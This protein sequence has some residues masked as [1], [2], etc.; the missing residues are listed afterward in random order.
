MGLPRR[1]PWWLATKDER[2]IFYAGM[3]GLLNLGL[4]LMK[5]LLFILSPSSFLIA[6]VVFSFGV[7][8][9]KLI[10]VRTYRMSRL[11]ANA[12]E[13]PLE[14]QYRATLK[15]G[16][17]LA[18]SAALYM[19]L[20]LPLILG[21]AV[22][23]SFDPLIA[24]ILALVAFTEIGIAIVGVVRTRHATQPLVKAIRVVNLSSS[25]VLLVL[26]QAAILSF[27]STEEWGWGVGLSALI[28]GAIA[29]LS[30]IYLIVR[31]V[32]TRLSRD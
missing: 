6:N 13:P 25:L 15:V 10:A 19:G 2:S 11:S 14:D 17:V 18:I 9:E 8:V 12:V 4:A 16:V 30:G 5:F 1:L 26:A 22:A 32:R 23:L 31:S 20:C 3:S 21:E 29:F 27:A 7:F 28:F 24:E